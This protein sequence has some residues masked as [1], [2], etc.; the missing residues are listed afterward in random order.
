MRHY[1]HFVIKHLLVSF[2]SSSCSVPS[3]KQ[4]NILFSTHDYTTSIYSFII[5]EKTFWRCF[6]FIF[7]IAGLVNTNRVTKRRSAPSRNVTNNV[8]TRQ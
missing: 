8:T 3:L 1:E 5:E 6:T 4:N 7:L 2:L